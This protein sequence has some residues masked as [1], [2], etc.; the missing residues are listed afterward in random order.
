MTSHFLVS[1]REDWDGGWELLGPVL[2]GTALSA[3]IA[4]TAIMSLFSVPAL[5]AALSLGVIALWG[6]SA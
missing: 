2:I 4:D 5:L 3:G 1:R 6:R